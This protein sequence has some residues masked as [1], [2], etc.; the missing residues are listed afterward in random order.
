MGLPWE[1]IIG[2]YRN[3]LLSGSF[4]KF[5]WGSGI[6]RN[7]SSDYNLQHFMTQECGDVGTH[8]QISTDLYN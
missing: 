4:S 3:E 2:V 1:T 5:V 8:T 6:A 7:G